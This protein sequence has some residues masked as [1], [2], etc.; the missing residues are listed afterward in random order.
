L[1]R[2]QRRKFT[3]IT[4][5]AHRPVQAPAINGS[6]ATDLIGLS[7]ALDHDP[8]T[9]IL[10]DYRAHSSGVKRIRFQKVLSAAACDCP[11]TTYS[12]AVTRQ[13]TIIRALAVLALVWLVV[14]GIRAFASSRTPTAARIKEQID[15]A[16]FADW[17]GNDS[18]N[19]T[20][21]AANRE[22]E[23]RKIADLINKLD[24]QEREKNRD[25]RVGEEFFRK[26][27]A[28]EK[29]LFIDLT[30]AE[31]MNRFMEAL[32]TMPPDQRRKFV[33]QGLKQITDGKTQADI[34]RAEELSPELLEKISQEGIRAYFQ[35]SSVETKLDLAPLM[36]SINETMQGLR[37]NQ[38]GRDR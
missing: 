35:K 23:I 17:S 3:P 13:S 12:L 20:K 7:G 9:T 38:F 5:R 25:Q 6:R 29:T 19:D 11:H 33:E 26:L 10:T 27:N 4:R 30:I 2:H 8:F 32:D 31:S 14:W 24:F 15:R 22:T 36:E 34:T 21:Q 18:T 37:G 16:R 28:R 1:L